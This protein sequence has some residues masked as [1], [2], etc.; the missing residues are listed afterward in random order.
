VNDRQVIVLRTGAQPALGPQKL[1]ISALQQP[2][3]R[4][5]AIA[6]RHP[7]NTAAA[8]VFQKAT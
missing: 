2:E 1:H 4:L 8:Q 6:L 3:C 7:D 5:L